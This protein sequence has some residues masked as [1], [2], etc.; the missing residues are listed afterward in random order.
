MVIRLQCLYSHIAEIH[1]VF[2]RRAATVFCSTHTVMCHRTGFR[3]ATLIKMQDRYD[4]EC[5]A[6]E[7]S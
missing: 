2:H 5:H 6:V 7:S 1:S 4:V 3:L